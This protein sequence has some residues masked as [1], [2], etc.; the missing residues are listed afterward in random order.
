ML[1]LSSG[2]LDA[3]TNGIR[4]LARL[5][6]EEQLWNILHE[7]VTGWQTAVVE[8]VNLGR[9]EALPDLC[10]A[11]VDIGGESAN[12]IIHLLSKFAD[13]KTINWLL[14]ALENTER[15]ASDSYFCNRIALVLIGCR[16]DV[17][18][19]KLS[20]LMSLLTRKYIQQL[21]W[22]IPA[23]QNRC[24]FYN[25]EIWRDA[26]Q[27]E[28]L[29]IKNGEQET[30]VGQTTTI[31]NIETLNAPNAALNLGGTIHGDQIGTQ[32]HQPNP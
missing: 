15:Y 3:R 8:L 26:I 31:V 11:L 2:H 30:A 5:K 21:F 27:N 19:D 25:Y 23:I 6:E 14:D 12:K 1:A 4:S 17:V 10:Q 20:H 13:R 24:K 9:I 32:S 29:E 22:V 7:K 28:K 16:S 18:E